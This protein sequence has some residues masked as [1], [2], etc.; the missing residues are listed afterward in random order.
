MTYRF[1]M[2]CPKCCGTAVVDSE[3]RVPTPTLK[4]GNCLW[5]DTEVVAMKVV[6][7]EEQVKPCS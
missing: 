2:V 4:C 1:T 7:V 5:D 6:R 3:S